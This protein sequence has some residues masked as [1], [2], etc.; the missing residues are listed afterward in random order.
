MKRVLPI[1]L[2]ALCAVT[3]FAQYPHVT[4]RQ[5]QEVPADSLAIADTLTGFSTNSAQPRWTLQTSQYM[6]DTVVVTGIVMIPP[7]VITYTASGWTMVLY[8]TTAN[9]NQWAGVLVRA[10]VADSTQLLADGF[11]SVSPGDTITMT[12]LVSEF[13]TQRGGS[14]TQF[15]PIAGQPI[16]ISATSGPLPKAIPRHVSDFFTGV[17]GAGKV[18]YSTGEPYE[19]MYVEFH[20]LTINNKVNLTRGTFSAVDSAGNEIS[21]Y[22]MSRYF[23][24]GTQSGWPGLDTTWV[25]KYATIG[26]GTRID[27]LRGIITTSSGQESPRGYRIAPM[28]YGDIIF[29]NV[30][31]PPLVQSHRRYPVVVTADTTA[32]VSVKVVQQ[33]NGSLPKTVS[34]KYSVNKGAFVTVPM[35]FQA[36]DTTYDGVI[37]RQQDSTFVRYFIE[38]S[39]SFGQNVRLANSATSGISLDTSKGF[40][41]YTVKST[42]LTVKDVQYTPYINGRS[43]YI[44]AALTLSGIVTADTSHIGLSP[45]T[46][47]STSAWYMQSGNAPWS[48]I[49]LS[50]SDTNMQKQMA[51]IRNGDSI[52]VTGT[53][54]EQFDVTRLGNITAVTKVSG[55]NPEPAPVDRT[56]G[57]LNVSNG[58]A[59]AEP[60]ESMLVRFT[61]V[62]VSD[63]NPTYSDVTEYAVN[64]G[65]GAVVVQQSGKYKYSNVPADTLLGKTILHVGNKIASLTGIVY[66]SFSQY[67]F[68]PRTDADFVGVVLTDVSQGGQAT[69]ARYAVSQNYPNP[70]NPATTIQ[71]AIPRAGVVTLKVYNI[72]GQEVRTLVNEYRAAGAYTVRFDA[73]RLSSGVYFY[74][75]QSGSFNIVKKMALV[76]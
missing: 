30:P 67:K 50:A 70:F 2:I 8:D 13:P 21:D 7:M 29:T 32:T 52:N 10:N 64:D 17:S 43:P 22:D 73:S 1:V 15:Q 14:L 36:V 19:G 60:Y 55:G 16:E 53:V 74:R 59:S 71:Y 75:L 61:N 5:I 68:V 26:N 34:L 69:P 56:T 25:A 11:M 23:T 37:P 65:T 44:G 76:K 57:T 63:V 9:Q 42:P 49:W 35:T 40:F 45:M 27:T 58:S 18:Q 3:G 4:I 33:L 31:P 38:V 54:Q 6:G 39:D 28:Y 12:G 72:L 41:F 20:N 51:A 66:Y 47:G 24:L 46:T 48:G 62:T